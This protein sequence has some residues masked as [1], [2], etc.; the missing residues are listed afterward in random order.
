[1][2]L[3]DMVD[4]KGRLLHG[5]L[6]PKQN[7]WRCWFARVV[8]DLEVDMQAHSLI[9]SMREI[10]DRYQVVCQRFLVQDPHD[11]I[12]QDEAPE[13]DSVAGISKNT[14]VYTVLGDEALG[15]GL[16]LSDT[17]VLNSV[18][19]FF[20]ACSRSSVDLDVILDFIASM[21]PKLEQSQLG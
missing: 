7:A 1:M 5:I 13:L 17:A 3:E 19:I 21:K 18:L 16:A 9:P 4:H 12:P 14:C 8:V 11:E 20:A 6:V 2:V 15:D 10:R